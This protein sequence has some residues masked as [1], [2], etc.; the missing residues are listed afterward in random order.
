MSTREADA[1]VTLDGEPSADNAAALEAERCLP[2]DVLRIIVDFACAGPATD[3]LEIAAIDPLPLD[4][5]DT[6][7]ED[8]CAAARLMTLA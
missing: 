2:F 5:R 4:E 1:V 6:P 8:E 3:E 7:D